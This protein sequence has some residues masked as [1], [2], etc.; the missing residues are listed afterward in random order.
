MLYY[1]HLTAIFINRKKLSYTMEIY[2]E[3]E[4]KTEV[5]LIKNPI[6]LKEILSRKKILLDS[7]ILVKNDEIC[8]EDEIV[9]NKDKIKIL[10]VVSGG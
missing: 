9:Q 7:V 10:S 4:N 1:T 6:K 2:Y 3:R 8:L 5:M